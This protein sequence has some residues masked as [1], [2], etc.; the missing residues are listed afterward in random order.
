MPAVTPVA[1]NCVEVTLP[2]ARSAPGISPAIVPA[3]V[4]RLVRA[5]EAVLSP[6]PPLATGTTPVSVTPP[7]PMVIAAG[8]TRGLNVAGKHGARSVQLSG[9]I[10][11]AACRQR[12]RRNR[13]AGL[14]AGQIA[15]EGCR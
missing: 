11:D 15:V 14:A 13:T 8:K 6:V 12:R 10:R 5:L 7:P 4:N 2:L 1:F 3:V 9:Q